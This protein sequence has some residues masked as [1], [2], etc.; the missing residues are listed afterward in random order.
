[1][2][3]LVEPSTLTFEE[4]FECLVFEIPIV[5]LFQK[6]NVIII[7][8]V[9]VRLLGDTLLGIFMFCSQYTTKG[10]IYSEEIL[11]AF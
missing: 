1:M 9:I 8:E 5:K 6:P 4:R 3:F 7:Y 11:P 10:R 2:F